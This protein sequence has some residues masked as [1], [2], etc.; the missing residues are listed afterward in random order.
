MPAIVL[1]G[2]QWGDEGKGKATD[3]LGSRVDYVVKFNGGNNAGHTVVIDG[4]KYAL[5][6]LPSGI[7]TPGVTPI[8]ANGVVVD[9]EVLFEELDALISRG[10][11]VSRL[12]VSANAHIIT[13]YHRTVDKVTE[14][15][16]GKRQIGTTGRGIGPTYADK[17]NRVGI[18]VQDLFDENILRQKVEGA[19][20]QKN[21][22]LVKVY[23][24]RAI[25]VDE[26]VTD[27]LSY[28]E[29]LRPMVADTALLLH[30][31][32]TA[33]KTVLFEGGQA[34]MLDVDHGTYPFVT[35]SNATSGGAVTGSGIG[36]N[37]IDR[38][39][40]V[41][42]AYTTRVGAGPF[43]TELFD[44]SGEFLRAKGF[45]FGTTTGRPRRCGWYDAPV[46]RYTARI[47]GVTDFVLT[48]LDVLTGLAAI[49]VC[50]AYSVDGVR[51]DEVPVSQS[52]FHHAKPIYEDFPGWTEDITGVRT[53]EELPR[54]AQD[55]VL[56]LEKMSGARISAIG[57]GPG[58]EAI[59]S[60]HDLIN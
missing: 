45:E 23:N 21:H 58:R 59:V 16:L 52:D 51:H 27:L 48:K 49:P 35:S 3:L 37:R 8:I 42:K 15:F 24:R 30:Q 19:L 36:P 41:V 34:T 2:A 20:A 50:V 14:R 40:A 13:Q 17:I 9:I 38:V 1:V 57:V 32:L 12:R 26:I 18:R 4:E 25:S 10:V 33:G 53:F 31:A 60:R 11:D 39:L 44:E 28:A 56:A 22:L 55:Y 47:N 6:L 54:N 29:R 46:A 43:P 7:L 5:H